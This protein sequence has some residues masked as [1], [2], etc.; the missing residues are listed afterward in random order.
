[1]PVAVAQNEQRNTNDDEIISDKQN[2]ETNLD[3]IFSK[4]VNEKPIE[5]PATD[6]LSA[7]LGS[8]PPKAQATNDALNDILAFAS[9]QNG[10]APV[11][12]LG[13]S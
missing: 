4:G 2:G 9:P 11:N 6:P 8:P 3:D 1:M 12:L 5:Q 7:L 13:S 10:S